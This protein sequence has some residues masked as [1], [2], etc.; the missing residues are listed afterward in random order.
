MSYDFV[1]HRVTPARHGNLHVEVVVQCRTTS[2]GVVESSDVVRCRPALSYDVVR[3]VNTALVQYKFTI[4]EGSLE[5][6]RMTM[7]ERICERDQGDGIKKGADCTG[8]VMQRSVVLSGVAATVVRS[9]RRLQRLSLTDGDA[10][11]ETVAATTTSFLCTIVCRQ[12]MLLATY[13]G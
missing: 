11:R 3:N 10:M 4:C 8:K 1:R 9:R 7:E 13:R 2:F 12:F 6:M 5:G